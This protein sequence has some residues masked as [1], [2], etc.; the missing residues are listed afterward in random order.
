MATSGVHTLGGS[1]LP[2]RFARLTP[3]VL[4][5]LPVFLAFQ[6]LSPHRGLAA[7]ATGTPPNAAAMASP[8]V[9]S[10]NITVP[11]TSEPVAAGPAI[12][13]ATAGTTPTVSTGPVREPTPPRHYVVVIVIDAGRASYY[14]LA[15]LPHIRALMRR[16]VV[17]N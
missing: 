7:G 5:L 3:F 8:G 12:T 14:S 10:T 6:T 9:S 11:A 15:Q 1:A 17:Y 2:A 13:I 16:G 4:L